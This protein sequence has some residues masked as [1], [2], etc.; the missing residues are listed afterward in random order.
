MKYFLDKGICLVYKAKTQG[1][2]YDGSSIFLRKSWVY[3][4]LKLV[5]F[6][7]KKL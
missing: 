7:R 2:S 3:Y 6:E 1:D 4:S 5:S